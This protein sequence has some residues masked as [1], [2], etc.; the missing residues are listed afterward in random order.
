[1]HACTAWANRLVSSVA[2]GPD[3]SRLATG[4]ADKTAAVWD[5][6]SGKRTLQLS[7]HTASVT[8]V[9]WSPD[10]LY[11]ATASRDNTAVLW[12]AGSGERMHVLLGHTEWVNSVAWSPDSLKVFTALGSQV[13]QNIR[14][15]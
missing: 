4:S 13:A 15:R 5:A 12:D 6:S 7:G 3:G 14:Y 1:M 10:R 11:V 2:W 9:A 8:S